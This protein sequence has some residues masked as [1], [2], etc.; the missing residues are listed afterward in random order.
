MSM[1][2]PVNYTPAIDEN[3]YSIKNVNLQKY[4]A[5]YGL[6]VG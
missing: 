1:K 2:T 3:G 5:S 6:A 4:I